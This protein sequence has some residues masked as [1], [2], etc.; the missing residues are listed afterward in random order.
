MPES[1]IDTGYAAVVHLDFGAAPH[2]HDMPTNLAGTGDFAVDLETIVFV[3][4]E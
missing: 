4:V 3:A 2:C 1:I